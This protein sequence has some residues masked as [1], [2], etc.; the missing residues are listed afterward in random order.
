[1][2]KLNIFKLLPKIK[3]N[4]WPPFTKHFNNDQHTG[5]IQD[6]DPFLPTAGRLWSG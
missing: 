1:M 6:T 3:R 2:N 5:L 4:G